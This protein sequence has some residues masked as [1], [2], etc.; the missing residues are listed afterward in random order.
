MAEHLKYYYL[1]PENFEHLLSGFFRIKMVLDEVD[2]I[3]VRNEVGSDQNIDICELLS[4]FDRIKEVLDWFLRFNIKNEVENN[5]NI[6][7]VC[8]DDDKKRRPQC[9]SQPRSKKLKTEEEDPEVTGIDDLPN[10]LLERI[11]KNL[12]T[13]DVIAAGQTC[14]RW[15][16]FADRM[17]KTKAKEICASWNTTNHSP[18]PSE[19]TTAVLLAAHGHL[20][21][22]L[23]TSKAKKIERNW[24]LNCI[25]SPAEVDC[26]SLLAA[27]G[28]LPRQVIT[29][30]AGRI[31]RN[32]SQP[33]HI[34]SPAEVNFTA[35]LVTNGHLP[36]QIL[37]DKAEDVH[38][39]ES[40][41]NH[42][43]F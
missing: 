25:L 16:S 12:E 37:T 10:E 29:T 18:T 13:K 21:N 3:A 7:G 8:G 5:Q 1:S 22:Q 24:H 41:Y 19:I 20:P 38:E 15:F 6:I 40:Y 43:C 31:A 26:A 42:L 34:P 14:R 27:S 9:Q 23:I 11:L 4:G 32:W 36:R 39:F 2:K 33:S 17:C 35:S 30:R 28:H